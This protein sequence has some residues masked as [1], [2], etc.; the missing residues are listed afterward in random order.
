MNNVFQNNTV[1]GIG[2]GSTVIYAVHRLGN[3]DVSFIIQLFENYFIYFY[4]IVCFEH[5]DILNQLSAS[6]NIIIEFLFLQEN[7]LVVHINKTIKR[8]FITIYILNLLCTVLHA[9]V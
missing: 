8:Y 2:S 6:F 5:Y 4:T 3:D 9:F 7:I 1:I